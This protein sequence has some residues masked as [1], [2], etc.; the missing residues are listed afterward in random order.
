MITSRNFGHLKQTLVLLDMPYMVTSS[1]IEMPKEGFWDQT[2]A[3]ILS[4]QKF[5][6]N[7]KN[8]QANFYLWCFVNVSASRLLSSTDTA[9]FS[10]S[11]VAL[12]I[13]VSGSIVV[14]KTKRVLLYRIV[15]IK[16]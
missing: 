11:P 7:S 14:A 12:V 15:S 5:I 4:H 3:S 16:A 9:Q 1:R 6:W 10:S 8:M 13:F 2:G